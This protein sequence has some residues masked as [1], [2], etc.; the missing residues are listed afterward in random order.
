VV[1]RPEKRK[2]GA[3]SAKEVVE[4]LN[5][6]PDN[7]WGRE[8]PSAPS[9]L[10]AGLDSSLNLDGKPSIIETESQKASSSNW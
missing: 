6:D 8:K 4:N 5:Q 7:L 9:K 2:E 3:Q 10:A 1:L